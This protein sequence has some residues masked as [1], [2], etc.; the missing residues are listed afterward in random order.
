MKMRLSAVNNRD[1]GV[2][3]TGKSHA[4]SRIERTYGT[5]MRTFHR[6]PSNYAHASLDNRHCLSIPEFPSLFKF[7]FAGTRFR[8][9]YSVTP[10]DFRRDK[11][12][13][14]RD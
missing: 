4:K 13:K 3:E 5:K 12:K 9:I 10:F 1:H 7:P 11:L 8:F 14:N 2:I 6:W